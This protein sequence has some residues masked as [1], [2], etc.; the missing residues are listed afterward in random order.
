MEGEIDVEIGMEENRGFVKNFMLL[1]LAVTLFG[2]IILLYPFLWVA[3][4]LM[5]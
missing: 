5:G 4:K 1:L 3:D 2:S